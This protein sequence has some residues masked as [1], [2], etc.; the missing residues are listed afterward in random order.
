MIKGQAKTEA[1]YRAIL[2]DSSSSLKEFSMDRKKY[3]NKYY[4]GKNVE[5]K[6]SQAAIM[7]RLVETI[8]MEEDEFDKR[9][10]MSACATSPTGNMV[11]FVENLYRETIDATDEFGNVTKTFEEI[12]K[13]A[14]ADCGYSGKGN[15]SYENI[16]KKFIGSDAEI[17]YNEIRKVR[18]NNL[19]VVTSQ[20]VT[21]AEN[22]VS[23]LRN[24]FATKDIVNLVNSSRYSVYDQL[25]VEAYEVDGHLFKSM[26]DKVIVDHQ[27]K[28][29]QP[30]DLKC[31]WSVENFY[32]EYY[33]YRRAYIQAYLYYYATKHLTLDENS[34]L[35]GYT[36][37][38]LQFIVCDSTNY[39]NPLVYTLSDEDMKDAYEGFVHKGKTYPGVKYL[40]D[41][42]KWAMDMNIWNISK[43]NY[44][45]KGIV[46]IK[47]V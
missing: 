3:Y 45:K 42:L 34:E 21:H 4:L 8:L 20:D 25:Q 2:L 27:E 28:I 47:S 36:V 22:I 14:F 26:M 46:N 32:E 15:G 9:F 35:Y 44:L 11:T 37:K 10:Y 6:D 41:E 39:Y 17:Y 43:S 7:G 13:A 18:A 19:T 29:I 1:V 12:S 23:E 38:P 31:T 5:D 16:I 24:N 40:I 30:Y 33:L